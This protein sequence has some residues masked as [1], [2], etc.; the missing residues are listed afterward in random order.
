MVGASLA[1]ALAPLGLRVAMIE[2]MV[3]GNGETHA[4]FD[5][6]TTALS[7][8]SRRTFE[9]LGVWKLIERE[10]TAIKRIHVSSRGRFGFA[11]LDAEEE[12]VSALG[13]VLPNRVLGR[14]LWQRLAEERIEV[15]A[16]ARVTAVQVV[17]GAAE[18]SY[19]HAASESRLLRTRL[20]VAADG[21]QSVLRQSAG[22]ASAH[23]E[24]SQ[25]AITSNVLTQR[26]HDHVAYE[27]FT[28]DGLIAMLPLTEGRC[29]VIW[30]VPPRTAERLLGMDDTR[31]LSE[32]QDAFGFRLGRLLRIGA[33]ATYSLALTRAQTCIAPRLAIIGNA[34]Q[35]LHPVAGQGF[36]LGLR[37]AAALAEVL[38]EGVAEF[39]GRLDAGDG[40][41]LER[42]R[43]WRD[44][45]RTGIIRFT[46]G[47]VRTFAA[48]L[49][50]FSFVRDMGLLAFDLM[51][52][53]KHA[54]SQLSLGAAGRVPRLARGASLLR[55]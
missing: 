46:D 51:P 54:L 6:R 28:A 25:V 39:G 20:A 18:I 29:G 55:R 1:L 7:N 9:A 19:E 14:A 42:Y 26:F 37:D 35:S 53:A 43:Q 44:A 49:G 12:G 23:K 34:A 24:Y 50:P 16:P 3:P 48:P 21:A 52:S 13:Y 5:E 30:T 32:L 2:A 36:N 17:E 31:L 47:L 45:D 15:I 33:R 4:S 11:R 41:L 27:R 8:G 40:L 38:A 22:I 10:A